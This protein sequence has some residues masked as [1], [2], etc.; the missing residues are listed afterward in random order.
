MPRII[1][2]S[3]QKGGVGKTTTAMN[4]ST[5]LAAC[6]H[7]VLVID[8][9]PQ[10]NTTTG[11]GVEKAGSAGKSV[12]DA[13]I[14]GLPLAETIHSTQVRNL[15]L[16]PATMDLAGAEA[17]LVPMLA[18]EQ[19][20]KTALEAVQSDYDYI[21]IDCPPS[22]GL[23]TI[24]ALVAAQEVM[25]PL[26]CEFFAMEGISQLWQTI[27]IIKKSLNS[28]LKV[29]GVLLTM[30]DSRNKLSGLVE[31]D[32]R[33]HLGPQVLQTVIPRNVRVSE[34]PSHGLPALLYDEK[35]AG[36]QAYIKLAAEVMRRQGHQLNEGA[37]A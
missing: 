15:S 13:L 31:S 30:Y 21:L 37:R 35:C 26:Q 17:E 25:V 11:F 34:A 9:D 29:L 3:N 18:R 5:A 32:V 22:L 10:G 7:R 33:E 1:A 12:Y 6:D 16:V 14:E 4:L 27:D 19:R 8:L 20:L 24:N 23:L 36:S 2:V 28:K